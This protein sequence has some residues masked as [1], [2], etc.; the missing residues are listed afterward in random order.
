M[1]PSAGAGSV[2]QSLLR[3]P[4][5]WKDDAPSRGN[6][7]STKPRYVI[8]EGGRA[9]PLP[10]T[11]HILPWEPCCHGR[12]YSVD[13]QQDQY[14]DPLPRR[15]AAGS[16]PI[17]S[18]RQ[19]LL[20]PVPHSPQHSSPVP[21]HRS[22]GGRFLTCSKASNAQGFGVQPRLLCSRR[23][24]PSGLSVG[25]DSH[26]VSHCCMAGGCRDS[27]QSLD[28]CPVWAKHW[29]ERLCWPR[30]HCAEHCRDTIQSC[31]CPSRLVKQHAVTGTWAGHPLT[32]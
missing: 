31:S 22:P 26:L 20:C 3:W 14:T 8:R 32:P 29:T 25:P 9:M 5:M 7:T 24:V 12:L 21:T 17:Q 10:G 16:A 19:I 18:R 2:L 11:C 4:G 6:D 1:S 28:G 27:T 23:P 30:P 13:K 15:R